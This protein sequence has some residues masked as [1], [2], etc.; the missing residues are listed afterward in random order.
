MF[1]DQPGL[2][3]LVVHN[4][5][6]LSP[7]LDALHRLGRRVPDDVSIVAVCPDDVAERA[8]PPLTSVLIPAEEIG[9]RAVELLMAK[10]NGDQS[11]QTSLLAPRLT[12]RGSTARGP[13]G[14]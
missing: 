1:R 13:R 14:S 12:E 10:L 3:G 2:T 8:R 11:D 4:E 6:A 5:A 9:R 7:L